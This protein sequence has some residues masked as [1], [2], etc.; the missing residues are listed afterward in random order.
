MDLTVT[1]NCTKCNRHKHSEQKPS[2]NDY[3]P[4]VFLVPSVVLTEH[5]A[6]LSKIVY[7]L[8]TNKLYRV[9]G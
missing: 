7:P 3:V 6:K 2:S 5:S 4:S 1:D 8:S 9:F